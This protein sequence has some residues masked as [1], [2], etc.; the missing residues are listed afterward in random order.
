MQLVG[1]VS[2]CSSLVGCQ[3]APISPKTHFKIGFFLQTIS[4]PPHNT[5]F[6]MYEQR[7][8]LLCTKGKPAILFFFFLLYSWDHPIV[9]Q[10]EC[11]KCSWHTF[12]TWMVRCW[13]MGENRLLV[14]ANTC[15]SFASVLIRMYIVPTNTPGDCVQKCSFLHSNTPSKVDA[16]HCYS[17]RVTWHTSRSA[18][19]SWSL[20]ESGVVCSSILPV[21][22]QIG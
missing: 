5:I 15:C 2:I 1:F 12:S 9:L 17:S 11:R 20:S 7:D 13:S 14:R 6:M 4:G 19:L 16:Y 18:L 10:V 22:V 8:P 3:C 21:R